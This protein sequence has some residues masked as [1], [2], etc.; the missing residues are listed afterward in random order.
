MAFGGSRSSCGRSLCWQVRRFHPCRKR[1]VL[2]TVRSARVCWKNLVFLLS[3]YPRWTSCCASTAA[4]PGPRGVGLSDS[5][6]PQKSRFLSLVETRSGNRLA[7][8]SASTP[9]RRAW[10]RLVRSGEWLSH[11]WTTLLHE[12]DRLRCLSVGISGDY[13]RIVSIAKARLGFIE[14]MLALAVTKLPEGQALDVRTQI[15]QSIARSVSGRCVLGS[16]RRAERGL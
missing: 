6:S 2:E 16:S 10:W 12:V 7:S 5:R 11:C 1:D 9:K 13:A 14:P 4:R 8:A 3:H 15:R